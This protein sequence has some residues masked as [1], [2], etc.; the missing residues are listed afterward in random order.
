MQ[1]PTRCK[2][3]SN[4]NKVTFSISKAALFVG[5]YHRIPVRLNGVVIEDVNFV[6]R[7]FR[8]VDLLFLTGV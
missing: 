3:N 7:C 4:K 1:Q 2:T 8:S 5:S 6:G